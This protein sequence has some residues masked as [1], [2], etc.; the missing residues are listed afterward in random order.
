MK[1]EQ[2]GARLGVADVVTWDE[3]YALG[4]DEIDAQHQ[5]LFTL[6]NDIWHAQVRGADRATVDAQIGR[7]ERY[8]REHFAAEEALM[9]SEGCPEIAAHLAEHQQFV[10]RVALERE[11]LGER[12]GVSLDMLHFLRD[13]LVS[14]ILHADAAYA[15]FLEQGTPRP[16]F[17][18]SRFFTRF[19]G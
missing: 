4:F 9:R 14:H 11:H 13:W 17:A 5:A 7:L 8:T 18:L 12:G 15:R 19:L 6:I 2:D 1:T 16:G 10:H 3:R